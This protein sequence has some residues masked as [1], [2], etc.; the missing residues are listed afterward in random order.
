MDRREHHGLRLSEVGIGCYNLSGAYGKKDV[1]EVQRTLRRAYE[2][3]VNF[4]DTAEAYGQ[5]ERVLGEAVAPFRKRICIATKVGVREGAQSNLSATYVR[6][7]CERSL[8][9]IGTDYIDLY[10]IHFDDPETPIAETVESLEKLVS[11]GKI[12]RYGVGHLPI[13]RIREYCAVGNVFSV[14]TEL[15]AVARDARKTV[16]PFC[17]E[18]NVA[19]IAF[20]TTGRGVLSGKI[21]EGHRFEAGDI[22]DIDP[23]FQRERLDSALRVVAAFEDLADEYGRTPA[24]MAIAWVLAQPG[25]VCALCGPSTVEHLEENVGGSGWRLGSADLDRLERLFAEE[26]ARWATEESASIRRILIEKLPASSRDAFR[27]LIYA[28]ESAHRLGWVDETTILPPF[29]ELFGLR[30]ELDARET[31]AKLA[32]LQKRLRELILAEGASG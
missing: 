30:G 17:A 2:L 1:E 18:Q 8:E 16:L 22:R 12:L 19:A 10:Q 9:Q 23:L 3:G 32:E 28:I 11:A 15:S 5:G 29:R 13:E 21:H 4:F 24:Q 7:A 26:D 31:G 14:L 20:S 27:D 25:V 6:D